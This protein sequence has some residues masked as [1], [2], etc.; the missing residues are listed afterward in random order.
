MSNIQFKNRAVF[1]LPFVFLLVSS[2]FSETR[3]INIVKENTNFL[4]APLFLTQGMGYLSTEDIAKIYGTD[5]NWFP[6]SKKV[7]L[8]VNGKRVIFR[9]GSNRV[10]V[11]NI[12][13]LMNKPAK[14][15]DGKLLVPL[16]FVLTKSF[17]EV[18]GFY[19]EWDYSRLVLR[20]SFVPDVFPP[21]YYSYKDKTRVVIQ[22]AGKKEIQIDSSKE[23][24][25]SVKIYRSK[26]NAEKSSI[27][28]ND[29]VVDGVDASNLERDV[30]FV[31]NLGTYSG[32]FDTFILNSPFRLVVDVERTGE[33]LSKLPG[34]SSQLAPSATAFSEANIPTEVIP[35]QETKKVEF[36]GTE[37]NNAGTTKQARAEHKITRI[38]IDA[39]HGGMDTGAIGPKGTKEKDI[40]LALSKRLAA[41][42][43]KDGYKVFLTRTD[44]TFIPLSERARYANKVMADLFVCIHCNA[45]ISEQTRGFEIYFLSE[46]A[47]DRAAE[48]VANMENSVIAL[49]KP[50]LNGKKDIERLLLSMAVNEFMNESASLCGTIDAEICK[51]FSTLDCRGV[52][53]A[54]FYVL[55]GATM[56]AVLI[57]TAFL[58][59]GNE[60]KLLNENK[61]QQ[62]I[63]E[64]IFDGIKEYEK[65]LK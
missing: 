34:F 28:I 55:R 59:N 43:K 38:V 48:A 18:S 22:A 40:N 58:S 42:L 13:K 1:F 24:Q 23:K 3:T 30:L 47:S 62:K 39:G 52:K 4:T 16:E 17:A 19:S 11:N 33:T 25:I 36:P 21:R 20:V 32:K 15:T 27:A 31:V 61:F 8:T 50:S 26:I 14:L 7:V 63:V 57:E 44:D 6:A 56:P 54:N 53:Q 46:N 45:S 65:R 10:L 41:I 64:N 49:E 5:I 35:P 2:V 37:D 12:E 29:G 51:N 9:I 60:E